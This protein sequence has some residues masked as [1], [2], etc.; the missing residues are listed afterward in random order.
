MNSAFNIGPR[1]VLEISDDDDSDVEFSTLAP[2]VSESHQF[3][4]RASRHSEPIDLTSD[5]DGDL[6]FLGRSRP[7]HVPQP[8]KRIRLDPIVQAGASATAR[9]RVTPGL[10]SHEHSLPTVNNG[11]P[12]ANNFDDFSFLH[13]AGNRTLAMPTTLN[14]INTDLPPLPNL[15]QKPPIRKK[16]K[17]Q[18]PAPYFFDRD[19]EITMYRGPGYERFHVALGTNNDHQIICNKW[20]AAQER[21]RLRKG[22]RLLHPP[23]LTRTQIHDIDSDSD[24]ESGSDETTDNEKQGGTYFDHLCL[25]A[26]LEV[27]PDVQRQFVLEK[28]MKSP[29]R[30]S[31]VRNIITLTDYDLV[32]PQTIISELLEL[33]SYPKQPKA[34]KTEGLPGDGTGKTIAWNRDLPK[35]P[36]YFKEAVI[37]LA[38]VF[39]HTPTYYIH[40]MVHETKSLFDTYVHLDEKEIK[41]HHLN[42]R[43]YA[44]L[45]F[46]RVVIEKKY[47]LT[48]R[49]QRIHHQYIQQVNELQAAKQ[50]CARE[51]HKSSIQKAKDDA[52]EVNARE[53]KAIG[54][55]TSCGCCFEETV[56]LNRTVICEADPAHSFCFTCISG[57]AES[58]VGLMQYE[59]KCMDATICSAN[60]CWSAI[61]KAIDIKTF[62]R[63]EF[64]RQQ[65]EIM[66]AD[67]EGLEQCPF[68]DFKAI[69][70]TVDV[71]PVFACQNPECEVVSC[72]KCH[73]E[74][75]PPKTCE[76]HQKENDLTARHRVEEARS[77]AVMRT[78]P[79]CKVKI[80]KEDGCN[81]MIC[82][83]CRAFMCYECQEDLTKLGPNVYNHFNK[84]GAKCSLY[85]RV[86]VDRHEVEADD[87]ER[88][89]IR[90]AKEED[91]SVDETRLQVETG[92]PKPTALDLHPARDMFV[93]HAN[94]RDNHLRILRDLQQQR[95]DLLLTD[96]NRREARRQIET[97]QHGIPDRLMIPAFDVRVAFNPHDIGHGHHFARRMAAVEP[98][99]N[100]T[101]PHESPDKD[102]DKDKGKGK[103]SVLPFGAG[104]VYRR[105]PGAFHAQS[106]MP[107]VDH[108][109]VP[110]Q[111]TQPNRA[112][113]PWNRIDR[114]SQYPQ[115]GPI[116]W[117]FSPNGSLGASNESPHTRLAPPPY[118]PPEFALN[119]AQETFG[120]PPNYDAEE[121]YG[122]REIFG[123]RPRPT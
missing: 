27:F 42:P 68:C 51:A 18:K 102:K 105:I 73:L 15:Q 41:F 30:K 12:P 34:T 37:L 92:K 56:P 65:A 59:M 45:R 78:C 62:D 50:H 106:R 67:L 72:R 57:L 61:A 110:P 44:R 29:W 24:S 16:L 123:G 9:P 81:K 77:D 38:K 108:P 97:L 58:Q 40:K 13:D 74:N 55:I 93:R 113:P 3:G 75:H 21:S 84:P 117:D 8:P 25:S 28:I 47:Q 114:R 17:V 2:A 26:V 116:S 100:N 85:D 104:N 88:E 22:M 107:N 70:D 71:N 54:A 66:A 89:A 96:R 64:N 87:A 6:T 52:E 14:A 43:P 36:M 60:L 23:P 10:P 112:S 101:Q 99:T 111:L 53:Q 20:D 86:G 32:I 33:S 76:E 118:A 63:L 80:I 119:Q 46:P 4:V 115:F 79:K 82:A 98:P 7:S 91:S 19:L 90:K 5:S 31:K 121:D 35:D 49:E 103:E 83:T 94:H 122:F 120:S 69:C 48:P 39:D 1:P 11:L 109:L 95:R